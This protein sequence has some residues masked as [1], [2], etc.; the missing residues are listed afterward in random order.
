MKKL[1]H[2]LGMNVNDETI[3]AIQ[4]YPSFSNCK[5]RN[6]EGQR[7]MFLLETKKGATYGI[8]AELFIKES[9]A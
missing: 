7:K 4:S 6:Y 2:Y 5:E 3:V 8:D 1:K 9:M